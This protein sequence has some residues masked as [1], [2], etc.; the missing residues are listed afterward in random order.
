MAGFTPD[1]SSDY[2]RV[3][4]TMNSDAF[5]VGFVDPVFSTSPATSMSTLLPVMKT[6]RDPSNS[7]AAYIFDIRRGIAHEAGHMFGL[8]HVRSDNRPDFDPVIYPLTGALNP[9]GSPTSIPDVMAYDV[10]GNNQF[11]SNRSLSITQVNQSS[12]GLQLTGPIPVYVPGEFHFPVALRT[13]NSFEALNA[14]LGIRPTDYESEVADRQLPS[15]DPGFADSA[16]H[17]L[18]TTTR[19]YGSLNRSGDY[20]VYNFTPQYGAPYAQRITVHATS[21]SIIPIMLLYDST[22]QTLQRYSS[23][24]VAGSNGFVL[25]AGASYKLVIG[26]SGG[27]QTG[28]YYLTIDRIRVQASIPLPFAALGAATT[29]SAV[30]TPLGVLPPGGLGASNP[31]APAVDGALA[32]LADSWPDRLHRKSG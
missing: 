6:E 30:P 29:A 3:G 5:D 31:L 17:D 27:V 23:P 4:H 13:Q 11:F 7:T 22:G 25:Q 32:D 9:L 26:S 28:G 20:N 18:S 24:T 21:G 8:V 14:V 19:Y 15:V 12:S 1:S 16:K 10:G 2:A